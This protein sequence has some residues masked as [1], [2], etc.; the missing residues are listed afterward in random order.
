MT[1]IEFFNIE[2]VTLDKTAVRPTSEVT[3][4][5]VADSCVL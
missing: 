5:R 4:K 2:S 3:T 1:K